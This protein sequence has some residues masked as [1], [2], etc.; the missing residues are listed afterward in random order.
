MVKLCTKSANLWIKSTCWTVEQ[1][2]H[3]CVHTS[4]QDTQAACICHY[5]FRMKCKSRRF[6]RVQGVIHCSSVPWE[7]LACHGL[8][9]SSVR[10][11]HWDFWH[12]NVRKDS[13][14]HAAA[15]GLMS[16]FVFCLITLLLP[17]TVF[18]RYNTFAK[19]VLEPNAHWWTKGKAIPLQN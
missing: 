19:A 5:V 3:D 2:S 4:H 15:A 6:N 13:R 16:C 9:S 18:G 1:A 11:D 10:N 12:T 8:P 14:L 17:C 7:L